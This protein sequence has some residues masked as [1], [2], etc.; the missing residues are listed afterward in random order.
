MLCTILWPSVCPFV[1]SR[2]CT[3]TAKP[4]ITQTTPHDSLWTVVFWRQR[5]FQNSDGDTSSGDTKCGWSRLNSSIFNRYVTTSRE[6]CRIGTLSLQ[7]ANNNL[8]RKCQSKQQASNLFTY[9]I[10]FLNAVSVFTV[11]RRCI[12]YGGDAGNAVEENSSI[13]SLIRMR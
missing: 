2:Y 9:C 11:W 12:R 3:K 8:Y 1:T 10:S 6:W 13:F 5:S 4:R 7:K